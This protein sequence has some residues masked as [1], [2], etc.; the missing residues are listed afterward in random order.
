[1]TSSAANLFG[2]FRFKPLE[3]WALT[4]ISQREINIQKGDL[5][6]VVI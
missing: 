3:G 2:A 6:R 5:G 4:D 1:L